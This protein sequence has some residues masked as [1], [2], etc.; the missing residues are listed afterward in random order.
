MLL[1]C[2]KSELFDRSFLQRKD[3]TCVEHNMVMDIM[4]SDHVR[5]RTMVDEPG[6]PCTAGCRRAFEIID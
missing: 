5:D 2:L 6:L 4:E 3:G 1:V